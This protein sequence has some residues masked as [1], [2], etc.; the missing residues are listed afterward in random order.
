MA[1]PAGISRE[2]TPGAHLDRTGTTFV[3]FA[4]AAS[5]VRVRLFD[6][7]RAPVRTESLEPQSDGWFMCRVEGVGAGTLYTFVLDGAEVPDPYARAL[8]FGVHGPARVLAPGEGEPR[9]EALPPSRWLLYELHVGTFTPE[10]TYRA[11]MAR[12]GD[13]AAL[14]VTA[15][16]LMP[17][18]AFD[19]QRGWGYDGVALYAPHAPY[20]TPDD[21]RAFVRAAHARGLSVIL[22]VVYNHFGPVGNYL[23]TY[24]HEYFNEAASTPWGAAPDFERAP[25]RRLVIENARYWLQE[26]GFD[27]LRIDA[28][29]AMKDASK[30]HVLREICELAHAMTPPRRV[31]FE[32]ERNDPS[33]IHELGADAI[34]ADDFHHQ[35]HVLLT[36]ERDGYYAAYE[37]TVEALAQT[38]REGWNA[39]PGEPSARD[40]GVPPEALVYCIQNHDQIGNRAFGTRLSHDAPLDAL[41]A[42]A[43]L[44]LFLPATPLLF[45]GEEWA[46]SSPFLYFTDLGGEVGAAVREGRRAEFASF[47]A[48]ADPCARAAIPDP[49]A[50]D[51]FERSKLRWAER[52]DAPHASVLAL[53]R[54]LL[55]L[56][57]SDKVLAAPCSWSEL[58]ATADGDL[59]EVVRRYDGAA[60]RLLVNFGSTPRPIAPPPGSRPI[61]ATGGLADGVLA[62]WTAVLFADD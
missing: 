45:M 33:L 52:E 51:T 49:E 14:G 34:W 25:M 40:A 24:A 17:V 8:P 56:R 50:K 3:V 46:P 32:D 2:L 28:T 26:F 35:V 62:P 23:R 42:A 4:T 44:Q 1:G 36:G 15:I 61:L 30:P 58:D 5:D 13:V 39:A 55:A 19:G 38:I 54:M 6:D 21:L 60:R 43:A 27:G 22:D 37:P 59:L 47:H 18:A 11:A 48:F 7:A 10:G 12:L 31:F 53:Y 16:E 41:G 29:H 9:R 57:K 20:G